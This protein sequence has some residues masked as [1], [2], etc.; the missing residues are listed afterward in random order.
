MKKTLLALACATPFVANAA[1][2]TGANVWVGGQYIDS[3][4]DWLDND[5]GTRFSLGD[6]DSGITAGADYGLSIGNDAVVL[7]GAAWNDKA[8]AGRITDGANLDVKLETDPSYTVYVAPGLKIN[9]SSLLYAK[10]S[11]SKAKGRIYGT[12]SNGD[13][14]S[15]SGDDKDVG[16]GFGLRSYLTK[17]V[18]V[19]ADVVRTEYSYSV[20]TVD[21]DVPVTRATIAIGMTF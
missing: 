9:E 6:S 1:D 10:V 3:S 18:F 16:Y 4:A 17:D 11:Y 7:V 21:I 19:N 14:F 8:S 13:A 12:D 20:D 15:L 2:F 5:D